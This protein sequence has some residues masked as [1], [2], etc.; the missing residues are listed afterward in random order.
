MW[1]ARRATRPWPFGGHSWTRTSLYV[2]WIGASH[3]DRWAERS[4]SDRT[5]LFSWTAEAIRFPASPREKAAGIS[6]PVEPN[7]GRE[8]RFEPQ[9]AV[10]L[11]EVAP[12]RACAGHCDR[13]G[14]VRGE[15]VREALLPQ[16]GERQ[17]PGRPARPAQGRERTAGLS[18]V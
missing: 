3:V 16:E 4:S 1:S 6:P 12:P 15:G 18:G 7:R 9:R 10:A 8:N 13:V 5:P 14:V 2:V 17:P 11:R